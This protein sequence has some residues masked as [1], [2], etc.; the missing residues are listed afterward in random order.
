MDDTIVYQN[1]IVGEG[2]AAPDG[3]NTFEG[4]LAQVDA[5]RGG[6]IISD[7]LAYYASLQ[8]LVLS[9]PLP[10]LIAE[11]AVPTQ[12]DTVYTMSATVSFG[13]TVYGPA[14]APLRLIKRPQDYKVQ[15]AQPRDDYAYVNN[16]AQYLEM[17]NDALSA[18]WNGL[19]VGGAPIQL[20]NAPYVQ[21]AAGTTNRLRLVFPNANTPVRLYFNLEALAILAGWPTRLITKVGE[22]RDPGGLDVEML[23][24]PESGATYEPPL[25]PPVLNPGGALTD[26]A[27]VV[28]MLSGLSLPAQR[29][30]KVVCSLPSQP[31]LVPGGGANN[32]TQRIFADLSLEGFERGAEGDAL[33][34]NAFVPGPAR[35]VKLSQKGPITGFQIQIELTDWLGI[36]RICRFLSPNDHA[37][38]KFCYC[39]L[40][41]IRNYKPDEGPPPPQHRM[42]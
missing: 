26:T 37:S 4:V 10:T 40:S 18:V 42:R 5:Q 28:E 23:L 30:V 32:A 12:L 33:I 22:P 3:G 1:V 7:G 9:T 19:V 14:T 34:Y 2:R 27:L 6:T 39:P 29:T 8:R 20:A 41:I 21:R 11:L 13:P 24:S 35:W 36:S 15:T 17:W 31:E 16:I 38:V 25:V